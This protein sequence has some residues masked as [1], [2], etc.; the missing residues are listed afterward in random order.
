MSEWKNWWYRTWPYDLLA[1]LL[2]VRGK[3]MRSFQL[4]LGFVADPDYVRWP[5]P[6]KRRLSEIGFLG[7]PD[8][9]RTPTDHFLYGDT[10]QYRWKCKH[11]EWKEKGVSIKV[12]NNAIRAIRVAPNQPH[13][14]FCLLKEVV[15]ELP[16]LD[17]RLYRIPWEILLL[18]QLSR[19]NT[20]PP[21]S[22]REVGV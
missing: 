2:P 15:K 18:L 1:D 8:E 13:F 16:P 6:N 21:Y 22:S 17:D 9:P 11:L 19:A 7:P 20:D 14:A 10:I 4:I 12:I 5:Q 3:L